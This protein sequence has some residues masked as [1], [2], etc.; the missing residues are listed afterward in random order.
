MKGG[1]AAQNEAM[2]LVKMSKTTREVSSHLKTVLNY[3]KYVEKKGKYFLFSK[4]NLF[5]FNLSRKV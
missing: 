5:D 3:L 2:A 4:N 1:T